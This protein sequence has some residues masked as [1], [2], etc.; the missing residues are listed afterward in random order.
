MGGWVGGGG[1][2]VCVVWGESTQRDARGFP[3]C[4]DALLA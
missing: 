3:V 2:E 4:L 1:G